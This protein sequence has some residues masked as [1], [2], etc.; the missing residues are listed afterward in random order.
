MSASLLV[1]DGDSF[2]H[3]AFHALPRSTEKPPP[4]RMIQPSGGQ[5]SSF[6]AMKRR[7]RRG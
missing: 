6:L 7:N 3:R 4:A 2:A 1:V 5:K